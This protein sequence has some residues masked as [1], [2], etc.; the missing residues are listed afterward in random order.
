MHDVGKPLHGAAYGNRHG[1]KIADAAQVIAGQVNEHGML[2]QFL[3]VVQ[4]FLLQEAILRGSGPAPSCPSDGHRAH[5]AALHSH[6][7]FRGSAHDLAPVQ[8][9]I[10][11]VGRGVEAPHA[12]VDPEGIAIEGNC[13]RKPPAC[14]GPGGKTANGECDEVHISPEGTRSAH[15]WPGPQ[16]GGITQ[17]LPPGWHNAT[18]MAYHHFCDS[19]G[20]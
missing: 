10:E 3:G 14:Q 5:R 6:E 13:T 1:P 17:G 16:V 18:R 4:E 19:V 12:A 20:S 7:H 2:R 15:F 9:D 8:R 11:V